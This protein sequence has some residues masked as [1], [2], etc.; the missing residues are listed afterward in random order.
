[1]EKIKFNP[2][3]PTEFLA[4]AAQQPVTRKA[5]KVTFDQLNEKQQF[6]AKLIT[7]ALEWRI[8]RRLILIGQAGTGYKIDQLIVF[9]IL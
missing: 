7:D 8:Q 1:M 9:P 3:K 4:Y 2:N 5:P 6:V